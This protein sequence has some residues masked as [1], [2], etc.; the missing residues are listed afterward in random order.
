MVKLLML[1]EKY[2]TAYITIVCFMKINASTKYA[3]INNCLNNLK[4]K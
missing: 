4:K 2:T 1:Q 3:Q